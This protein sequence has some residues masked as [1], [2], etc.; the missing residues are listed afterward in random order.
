MEPYGRAL[1]AF[2]AGNAAATLVVLRE[3]GAEAQ[4]PISWFFRKPDQFSVLE[5]TALDL[6]RGRVL[7]VGA[8]TGLHSLVLQSRGLGVTSLDIDPEAVRIMST[9][10]V[11][12]VRQG[13]ILDFVD[14]PFDTLLLLGHGIGMVEDLAGL[15]R[16]LDHAARLVRGDGQLLLDSLDVK[17]TDAPGHIAY[18]EAVEGKGR[19][20]GE[21]R[22]R[23]D[24]DGKPGPY[25]GWLHVDPDMLSEE[26]T[27]SG[28]DCEVVYATDGGEFLARLTRRSN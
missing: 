1:A 26:A 25:C 2:S 9:N 20:A 4:L 5:S 27:A 19:Y 6:C 18:H 17:R 12:D 23:F 3:D 24:F 21:T 15:R 28:W 22:I 8:G 13:D 10:G 16:F 7:D 14:G 11:M